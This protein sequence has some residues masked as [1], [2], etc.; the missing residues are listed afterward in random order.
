MSSKFSYGLSNAFDQK[1]VQPIIQ[2]GVVVTTDKVASRSSDAKQRQ[3]D[4]RF[5]SDPDMIRCRVLSSD[6]DKNVT[7]DN[8]TNCYPLLPKHL[9]VKP[10]KGEMVFIFTFG[11][12]SKFSDR[13]YM[14]P[15]ISSPLMLDRDSADTTALS[16]LSISPI[17]PNVDIDT[18]KESIG[19]YPDPQDVAVQGRDN[20]DM[21]LKDNEVL[22]R[23]GQH[24]LGNN[25]VF[26][27][28]DPGY[29]QI[30]F[31]ALLD[32][33]DD[34]K[35]PEYGSVT[36]I[37]S[38]KINLLTH[39]NGSPR[40]TLTSP[41]EYISEEELLKILDEAHPVAFGDTLLDYLKKLELA[42]MNHV[43]RFPGKKPSAIDGENYIKEYLEYPV[44]TILS[45]NIKIN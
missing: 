19:I 11:E 41:N 9:N 26:N 5:N 12:G 45:K 10:K 30:K 15:L 28:R 36:N 17:K 32:A 3:I 14:G 33:G 13:F 38:S 29:I 7:D 23:A 39:K 20:S 24:V 31:N 40:F 43:H 42:F 2:L 21:I 4:E 8:L 16:S 44:D 18:I 35:D 25:M 27:K 6:W 1:G 37:V 34:E 22:L